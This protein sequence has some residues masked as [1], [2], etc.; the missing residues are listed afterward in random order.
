VA[1][2]SG[3]FYPFHAYS[4]AKAAVINPTRTA[5]IELAKDTIRVN[6]ICPGLINTPL[7]YAGIPGGETTTDPLLSNTQPIKRAGQAQ[8]I[9][10]MATYLASD[11]A[12]W[13]TGAAMVVD[14]GFSAGIPIELLFGGGDAPRPGFSGPSFQR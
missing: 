10:N 5:A 12:R 4:A 14:G 7:V 8:D 2:L 3:S 13:I 6:C 11:E 1:G 9:A